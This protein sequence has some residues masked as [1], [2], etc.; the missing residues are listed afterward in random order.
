MLLRF[1]EY[2]AFRNSLSFVF[3]MAMILVPMEV[4][5]KLFWHFGDLL[6]FV[7]NSFVCVLWQCHTV[8]KLSLDSCCPLDTFIPCFDAISPPAH[9]PKPP[10]ILL[11][12]GRADIANTHFATVSQE[13]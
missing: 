10:L 2:A 1:C 12:G 5:M 6:K 9:S 4:S 13:F 11:I 7:Q 8:F 3:H